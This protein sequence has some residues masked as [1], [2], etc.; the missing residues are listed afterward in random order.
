MSS[1]EEETPSVGGEEEEVTDLSNRYEKKRA[2]Q[3]RVIH[4]KCNE[5]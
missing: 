5:K 4:N 2:K 3:I 1:D